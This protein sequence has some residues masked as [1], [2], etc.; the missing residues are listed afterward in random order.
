MQGKTIVAQWLTRNQHG[1]VV[2]VARS[3][4]GGK[5]WS[6]ARTPHPNVVSEFGFVSL[7]ANGDVIWLDGRTLKDGREG[8]G[9]MQLR[10]ASL[11][12]AK[13]TAIDAKVCDCCQTAMAMTSDGP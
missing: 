8:N 4:D 2:H 12:F 11:P 5:T 13:E 10:Y 9:D 1:S 6:P 7:A 3:T